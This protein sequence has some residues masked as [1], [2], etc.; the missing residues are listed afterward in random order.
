MRGFR[1]GSGL[2]PLHASTVDRPNL[3]AASLLD[4][5][6]RGRRRQSGVEIR[7][8]EYVDPGDNVLRVVERPIGDAVGAD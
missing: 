1:E 7:C 3:D 8:F 4:H 2:R 6:I 5:G